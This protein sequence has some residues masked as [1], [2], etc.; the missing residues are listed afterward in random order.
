MNPPASFLNL[1]GLEVFFIATTMI[2]LVINLLQWR[3]RRTLQL[4]L[5]NAL[6]ALF[7]DIK[8]KTGNV[9]FVYNALFNPN[10]PHSNLATLRWEYGLFAQ[11]MIG[12][13]QGFQEAVV[14]VLATLNPKDKEGKQ[15]F[16]A[17]DYGLTEQE[18]TWRAERM[19]KLQEHFAEPQ[20]PVPTT[21]T[22]PAETLAA[23][24][25]K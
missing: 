6:I 17:S 22:V 15:A 11:E 4:P 24:D 2:S 1:T 18:K 8:A 21:A 13:F 14:G 20:P 7:N 10:S 25:T 23:N 12:Y 9:N 19:R 3:D 16:R 5:T